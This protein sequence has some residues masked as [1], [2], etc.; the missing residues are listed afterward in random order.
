MIPG[1]RKANLPFSD[2]D[3]EA[4]LNQGDDIE[5]IPSENT[6]AAWE[7]WATAYDVRDPK[8]MK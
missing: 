1:D 6:A 2:E 7:E 5:S 8:I 4:L 3:K